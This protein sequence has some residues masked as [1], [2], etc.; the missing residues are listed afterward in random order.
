M[1]QG[2]PT[3]EIY[4]GWGKP[5]DN[6]LGRD[7]LHDAFGTAENIATCG[8]FQYFDQTGSNLKI[9]GDTNQYSFKVS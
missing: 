6:H 4:S 5:A 3:Q 7:R 2:D 9:V 1:S 8:S